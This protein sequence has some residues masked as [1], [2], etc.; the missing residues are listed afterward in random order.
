MRFIIVEHAVGGE[1]RENEQILPFG[2]TTVQAL[3]TFNARL[4]ES[5]D[6]F[7]EDGCKRWLTISIAP[8]NDPIVLPAK[9][10]I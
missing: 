10:Q 5:I 1:L 3:A 4:L 7:D 6:K 8:D 2:T 9:E